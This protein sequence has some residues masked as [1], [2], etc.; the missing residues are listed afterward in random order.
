VA[1]CPSVSTL[2]AAGTAGGRLDLWDFATSTLRPVATHM[3]PGRAAVT[4]VHFARDA[5]VVVACSEMGGV[6]V[7]RL[8]NVAG[9]RGEPPELQQV[10]LEE[11]LRANVMKAALG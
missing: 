9:E 5:P 6:M 10:R 7:L 8:L 1:W 2:F 11:A 3:M 4:G